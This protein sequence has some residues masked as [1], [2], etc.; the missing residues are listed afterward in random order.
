LQLFLKDHK[1]TAK[2][3]PS[4]RDEEGARFGQKYGSLLSR[5]LKDFSKISDLKVE[6]FSV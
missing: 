3:M 1:P 5:N 4:L 6:D 2:F